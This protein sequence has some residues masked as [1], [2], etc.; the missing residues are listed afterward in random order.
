MKILSI[1][2]KNIHSFKGVH[3]IN[4]DEVPLASAGLF[5]ITGP[6]GSGK[7]T[8]LDAIT[9]A[10]FNKI[11]RFD[12]KITAFE[13][14][15]KGS[16]I[17]RG[18]E[19]AFAEVD[20]KVH[21]KG[22]R[23]TWYIRKKKSKAEFHEYEMRIIELPDKPL[24]VKKGAVPSVNESIIGL[25]Y[26][27]FLKSILL[28]QGEFSKFLKST[29]EERS[30][31]LEHITGTQ[32]YRQIGIM[33]FEKHKIV[34][35]ELENLEEKRKM[36]PILSVDEH[37]EIVTQLELME[38]QTPHLSESYN[39]LLSKIKAIQQWQVFQSELNKIQNDLSALRQNILKAEPIKIALEKHMKLDKYRENLSSWSTEK[40]QIFLKNTEIQ[41]LNQD[42]EASTKELNTAINQ[43]QNL[44]KTKVSQENFMDAMKA[45]EK[46]ISDLE[47]LRK[48][49]IS[50]GE[51]SR[52]LIDSIL[53]RDTNTTLN[54]LRSISQPSELLEG[55]DF[56]I[57]ELGQNLLE[58]FDF[59]KI[60]RKLSTCKE[61]LEKL[62]N[63][64]TTIIQVEKNIGESTKI[65]SELSSL[66][67]ELQK[68]NL[69]V[70]ESEKLYAQIEF[71][72]DVLEKQKL[73]QV[74][75]LNLD[76]ERKNLKSGEPCPLCGS[77]NHPYTNHVFEL[78]TL[79]L[80]LQKQ[81]VTKKTLHDQLLKNKEES[82]KKTTQFQMWEV[83][84]KVL[85]TE[86]NSLFD[87]LTEVE[88][89]QSTT[90]I[91]AEMSKLKQQI[92]YFESQLAQAKILDI[93]HDVRPRVLELLKKLNEFQIIRGQLKALYS[94]DDLPTEIN[95]IQTAFTKAQTI[96]SSHSG[97]LILL[98]EQ[99][100]EL[101]KEHG[102]RSEFLLPHLHV[103]GYSDIENALQDI[104]DD[105][106]YQSFANM[107]EDLNKQKTTLKT[108]DKTLRQ[109]I[110]ELGILEDEAVQ[111]EKLLSDAQVQKMHLEDINQKIGGYK[112]E[113]KHYNDTKA[114]LDA[115]EKVI[116]DKE[117]NAKKWILLNDLIG[118]SKGKNYAQFA[119]NLS[120]SH[121]INLANRR[122]TQLSDRYTFASTDINSDLEVIDHW[123]AASK[124][125]VKTLSGGESFILSLALALGLSD[126]ASHNTPIETLII[127]EGFSTLDV[128]SLDFA[129]ATIE[130]LQSESNKSI[131]IISHVES[132]K[133]RISTQIKVIKHASGYSSIELVGG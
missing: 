95:Q 131:G 68:L 122:L 76:N 98:N 132:L 33:A 91:T 21:N 75:V 130:K 102:A 121:L 25:N 46:K 85:E 133:E 63:L 92:T 8:I 77:I 52:Q 51:A 93:L 81:Y 12:S 42:Y 29:E 114:S 38:L 79:E 15:K 7:S 78:G 10:L 90:A 3:V 39:T 43:M 86:K 32:L 61:Q 70:Q 128:E 105:T 80:S 125:S 84:L 107:L 97:R 119:Q 109:Q 110:S 129:L 50:E 64:H 9:L 127:D 116:A 4:F 115:L 34:K 27:Q 108:K 89:S 111:L 104:L 41:K 113:L 96:Q 53:Q 57:K 88:K 69:D 74:K 19:D 23:S 126:M 1:R 55:I 100:N 35:A 118:D 73:D 49:V 66:N 62:K 99:I 101:V 31:L 2:I 5:A 22:Y 13:I 82:T 94:G 36:I 87:S 60:D 117:T 28:S 48:V 58:D 124:R 72:L 67:L 83:R 30:Q 16:V 18:T 71:E 20:Y 6:T 123:Q 40:K 47:H 24:D 44:T 65:K 54:T 11:P 14:D 26:D 17:T 106:K 59:K 37:N 112:N 45:F 120:F 103:L 56:S